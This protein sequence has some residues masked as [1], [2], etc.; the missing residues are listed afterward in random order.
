MKEHILSLLDNEKNDLFFMHSWLT[1]K[2]YIDF[3]PF[4]TRIFLQMAYCYKNSKNKQDYIDDINQCV[5]E[6]IIVSNRDKQ[7]ESILQKMFLLDKK[8]FFR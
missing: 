5:E 4:N 2:D 6:L 7:L 8:K 3:I 1:D